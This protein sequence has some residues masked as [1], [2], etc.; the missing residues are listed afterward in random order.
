VKKSFIAVAVAMTL[1]SSMAVAADSV[2]SPIEYMISSG[3]V[4]L[5]KT[6]ETEK[7]GLNGYV[8]R[9][10]DGTQ[11]IVYG[12]DDYAIAGVLINAD[13]ENLTNRYAEEHIPKPDYADIAAQLAE[14]GSLVTEGPEGAPEMYVFSDPNCPYCK[15][16]FEMSRPYVEQGKV[17]INWVMVGFL[18]ESSRNIAA[19]ILDGGIPVMSE[20]KTGEKGGPVPS[21]TPTKEHAA[22]LSLHQRAMGG[23]DIGGT[24]GFLYPVEG[25]WQSQSGLPQGPQFEDLLKRIGGK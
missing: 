15:R 18:A 10:N 1:G 20:A 4:E 24:P 25:K 2:P 21:I 11:T 3:S 14:K 23:A 12:L 22:A 8:I 6:F 7:E 19:A 17:R 13:G 16:F 9:Q 5:V